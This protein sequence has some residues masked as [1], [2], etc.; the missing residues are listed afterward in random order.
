MNNVLPHALPKVPIGRPFPGVEFRARG[1]PVRRGMPYVVGENEPELFVPDVNGK[2]IPN[3]QH[4][5]AIA[6]I[7]KVSGLL[8]T[9]AG[10]G[11]SSNV[12]NVNSG[13][14]SLTVNVNNPMPD[15][16]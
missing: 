12:N 11:R 9:E 8:N 7:L 15:L 14:R 2:I 10:S 5:D 16:S 1:G 3:L 4:R 6:S 13:S